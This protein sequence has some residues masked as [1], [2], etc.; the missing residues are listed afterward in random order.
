MKLHRAE[1]A[2][3]FLRHQRE[4]EP[5]RDPRLAGS[6]RPL[7]NQVLLSTQAA[8]KELNRCTIEEAPL[9]QDVVD[10]VW[11]EWRDSL[12]YFLYQTLITF[13]WFGNLT[14]STRR[15]FGG[16]VLVAP[17]FDGQIRIRVNRIRRFAE[18]RLENIH[19]REVI[20]RI[21]TL[22]RAV[23]TERDPE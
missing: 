7:Q 9:F 8:E 14:T 6:G 19:C 13:V 3:V 12:G 4:C 10:C 16:R 15:G 18:T 21:A 23:Q 20:G 17:R 22:L 1:L 5:L 11:H 2:F